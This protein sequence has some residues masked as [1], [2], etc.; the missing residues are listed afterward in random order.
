M[1]LLLLADFS[2]GIAGVED[3]VS[4]GIHCWIHKTTDFAKPNEFRE[5]SE[6]LAA[7]AAG[8]AIHKKWWGEVRCQG[9]W[10]PQGFHGGI[11][12]NSVIGPMAVLEGIFHRTLSSEDIGLVLK[13]GNVGYVVR[14]CRADLMPLRLYERYESCE[15][16]LAARGVKSFGLSEA[17]RLCFA[18]KNNRLSKRVYFAK[19]TVSVVPPMGA[20]A[21]IGR[22]DSSKIV[23]L[24]KFAR[25]IAAY[26]E[27]GSWDCHYGHSIPIPSKMEWQQFY[28]L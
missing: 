14:P 15:A 28:L 4:S 13:L 21:V 5:V 26:G 20:V 19:G 18:A 11:I 9:G 27:D 12:S 3:I 1:E 24:D 2:A 25:P 17:R 6:T 16:R 7:C 8:K 10:N 23:F 22:S